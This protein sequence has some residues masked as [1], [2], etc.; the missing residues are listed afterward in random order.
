MAPWYG[1]Q[2]ILHGDKLTRRKTT[3][4]DNPLRLQGQYADIETGLHFNRQR[5]Y[6]ASLGAFITQDPL[7][8]GAGINLYAYAP[9]PYAWIDPYGLS[10]SWDARV[11]RWRNR[12]TGRF[13]RLPNDPS[14]LVHNGRIDYRDVQ[15]WA[16]AHGLPNNWTPSSNFPAG[17]FRYNVPGG[18]ST[19]GH[20]INPT[21]VANFPG[22]NS[23][24]GPTASMR[25]S[26]GQNFRTDG[27]WG[28]FGSD[29]N[30]AHIPMD[31]SPY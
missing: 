23:A 25:N 16:N 20:G 7:R 5:Y 24:T 14:E 10:C 31:N 22:S 12:Q 1:Q 9:N 2:T 27:T 19:H 17:G 26:A 28:T 15:T 3:G 18:G 30:G 11:G 8:L 13:Q 4:W 29:P 21:A 6:D